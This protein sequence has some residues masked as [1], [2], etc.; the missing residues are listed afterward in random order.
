MGYT[1][2]I[3]LTFINF[4]AGERPTWG[5]RSSFLV[6]IHISPPKI[7]KPPFFS[8]FIEPTNIFITKGES[9]QFEVKFP[10]TKNP[11][12]TKVTLEDISTLPPF[13]KFKKCDNNLT[14]E[15]PIKEGTYIID[16]KLTDQDQESTKWM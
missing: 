13:I 12:G 16:V 4:A 11:E 5:E 15:S 10:G 14:L 9:E 1:N 6:T 2:D 3:F 8:P 7:N